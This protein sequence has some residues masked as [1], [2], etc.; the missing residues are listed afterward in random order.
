MTNRLM[1][2]LKEYRLGRAASD[3]DSGKDATFLGLSPS[4]EI[5]YL[6]IGANAAMPIPENILRIE[7]GGE[8]AAMPADT[9]KRDRFSW[10]EL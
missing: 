6:S 10:L 8:G 3:I 9:E 4:G 1:E 5:V 2:L 7:A